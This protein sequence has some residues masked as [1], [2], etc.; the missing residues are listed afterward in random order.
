MSLVHTRV[1]AIMLLTA[2]N[3]GAEPSQIR[4]TPRGFRVQIVAHLADDT[5]GPTAE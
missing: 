3:L 1:I 5:V 4:H 2:S